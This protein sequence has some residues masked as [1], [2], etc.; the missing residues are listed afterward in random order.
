MPKLLVRRPPRIVQSSALSRHSREVFAAAEKE[1]VEVSRRDGEPL[2][3]ASKRVFDSHDVILEIAAQLIAVSLTDEGPLVDR[4]AGP[5]P[6]IKL[7]SPPDQEQC[8]RDI[9]DT[10][11]GAFV[12]HQPDRLIVELSAWRNTAEAVAAGWDTYEP[13][14]IEPIDI[15]RP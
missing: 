1:P 6:W 7:L 4:L 5:F 15:A 3:L 12:V 2:I 10:A 13:D 14:W 8:A 9:L 11:R